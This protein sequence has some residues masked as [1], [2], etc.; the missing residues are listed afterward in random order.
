MD[1][2]TKWFVF[3]GLLLL[4]AAFLRTRMKAIAVSSSLFYFV[5]G[6]AAGPLGLDII[7]LTFA[8]STKWLEHLAEVAV[9]VSLFTSGLKLHMKSTGNLWPIPI[10]LA[11]FGM[12]LSVT[13]I[14]ILVHYFL[15][16]PWGAAILFAAI[17]SPTDPVLASDVQVEKVHDND[18]VRFSITG[19]G[20]LNDGTAF[21]FV[22]L[23]LGVLG[24]HDLG[25]FGYKWVLV[26][27]L[28]ATV[29][30]L[31]IGY[32]LGLLVS[33]ISGLI[34]SRS[35]EKIE[36]DELLA[37]GL[38][39]LAYGTALAL[40]AYGFL[41]VFAAGFALRNFDKKGLVHKLGSKDKSDKKVSD[42]VLSFNEQLERILEII[43]VL[44][45]GAMMSFA[46]F[47]W[48]NIAVGLIVLL[49]L[50]PLTA[51]LCLTGEKRLDSLQK[52]FVSWFGVRGVGSLYYFFYVMNQDLD[53]Q[54]SKVI[55]GVTYVAIFLS[56]LIHGFS[57]TP[58]MK[59]YERK[60]A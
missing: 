23:G 34:R 17:I 11:T 56:L 13:T 31:G 27:L 6:L 42:A 30:G 49:I 20:C 60:K 24:L 47:T 8:D 4:S 3:V 33:K 35:G 15:K 16:L 51:A 39:A 53:S 5:I 32:G 14:S 18:R 57:V 9:V 7:S 55:L 58:M 21:P 37:L 38:I 52:G 46:F 40:H 28:W 41:A 45:F 29:G 10:R 2:V 25:S 43:L 50:R 54:T 44:I 59:Y 48:Q 26:D 22:M 36:A 1:L 19:E 12:V